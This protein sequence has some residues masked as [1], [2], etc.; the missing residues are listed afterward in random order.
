M[1]SNG[2]AF[3]AARAS[4]LLKKDGDTGVDDMWVQAGNSTADVKLGR[5]EAMDLFPLGKDVLVENSGYGGYHANKLRGRF[6][7]DTVHIAPGFNAGPARIEVGLV[8]SK[9]DGTTVD[10]AAEMLGF[11]SGEAL[12]EARF[13]KKK[14]KPPDTFIGLNN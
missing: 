6:G 1:A 9:E 11:E 7:K 14:A 3:V 13:E 5:F 8:Y 12:M 10:V 2:D 4:L